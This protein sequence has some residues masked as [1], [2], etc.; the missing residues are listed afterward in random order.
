MNDDSL[1]QQGI[2]HPDVGA[3][4]FEYPYGDA[5][6]LF[7]YGFRIHAGDNPDFPAAI[8]LLPG[9]HLIGCVA[10]GFAV[11]FAEPADHWTKFYCR[12]AAGRSTFC[13]TISARSLDDARARC[14]AIGGLRVDGDPLPSR[15]QRLA[16]QIRY[17]WLRRPTVRRR[18]PLDV[19]SC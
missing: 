15:R 13:T 14:C 12:V 6:G 2:H 1:H 9:A 19:F 17:F 7:R 8:R 10:A 3:H 4:W 18:T 16:L 11:D 5:R